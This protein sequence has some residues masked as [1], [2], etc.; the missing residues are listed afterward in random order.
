MEILQYIIAIFLGIVVSLLSDQKVE[1]KKQTRNRS[2][3]RE[4]LWLLNQQMVIRI[5]Y[6]T[7][8]RI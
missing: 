5:R 2:K 1:T 3:L 8:K 4:R 6:I 7:I